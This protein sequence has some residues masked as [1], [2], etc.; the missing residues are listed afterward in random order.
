M[1][2]CLTAEQWSMLLS[3]VAYC[4]CAACDGAWEFIT[5]GRE[6]PAALYEAGTDVSAD[7]IND[8]TDVFHLKYLEE[9]PERI[10]RAM[11]QEGWK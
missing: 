11:E 9:T 2:S 5:G 8:R 4:G 1:T 6:Q 7:R 10:L 3:H